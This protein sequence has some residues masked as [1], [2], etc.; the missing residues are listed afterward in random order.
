[1]LATTGRS[2][3]AMADGAVR[4]AA[5]QFTIPTRGGNM[6]GRLLILQMLGGSDWDRVAGFYNTEGAGSSHA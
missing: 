6:Q 4:V 1:V 3:R 5:L 2:A